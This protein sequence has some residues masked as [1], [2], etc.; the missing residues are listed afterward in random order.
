LCSLRVGTALLISSADPDVDDQHVGLVGTHLAQHVVGVSRLRH[1][2]DLGAVEEAGDSVAEAHR[3]L[4]D[5]AH[6]GQIYAPVGSLAYTSV[7]PPRGTH[8]LKL[9]ADE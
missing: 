8:D 7:P 2:L 5:H 1:D 9:A 6:R 4:T 3:V